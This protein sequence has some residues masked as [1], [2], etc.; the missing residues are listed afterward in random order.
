MDLV[1]S[2]GAD[3]VSDYTRENF[4]ESGQRYDLILECVGNLSLSSCRRVLNPK[5]IC[6]I[7]GAPKK[8]G[9]FLV[10]AITAPVLSWFGSQKFVGFMAKITNADLTMMGELIAAGKLTPV[11]DRRYRL[12][13]VPEAI[14]YLEEG[15][16]RGKVVVTFQ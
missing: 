15:H 9:I 7:V 12:S 10:R 6:A 2:I 16:A 4:A 14:R 1:R 3:H 11:I 5:G 13:E 8:V